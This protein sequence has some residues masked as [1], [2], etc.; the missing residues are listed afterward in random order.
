MRS[1]A[2]KKLAT[3]FAKALRSK[4]RFARSAAN[5]PACTVSEN[6]ARFSFSP[7]MSSKI[8]GSSW[9]TRF[10]AVAKKDFR[11]RRG[12]VNF[13]PTSFS[14]LF[15][16]KILPFAR[17]VPK[18]YFLH[19]DVGN[20]KMAK[21]ILRAATCS[22]AHSEILFMNLCEV[23]FPWDFFFTMRQSVSSV[24]TLRVILQRYQI[25]PNIGEPV[26]YLLSRPFYYY[27][28]F[29]FLRRKIN[30]ITRIAV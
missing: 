7:P 21:Y 14:K 29:R 16:H 4:N 12:T 25:R 8:Y 6:R 24:L 13:F 20:V 30:F 27:F 15:F 22:V 28:F 23:T 2:F 11:S 9:K 26:R 10:L 19:G 17:T 18:Y 3:R 1:I 5:D